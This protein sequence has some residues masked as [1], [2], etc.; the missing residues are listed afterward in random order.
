MLLAFWQGLNQ[1]R[2]GRV[3]LLKGLL[4][5]GF[6]DAILRMAGLAQILSLGPVAQDA[7]G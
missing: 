3:F 1:A 7:G 5:V 4:D 2:G 6:A